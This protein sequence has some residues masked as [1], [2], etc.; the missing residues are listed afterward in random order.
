M[1]LNQSKCGVLTVTRNVNSVQSSYHLI[2]DDHTSTSLIKKIAVQRD[3]G[4]LIT[5]YLKWRKQVNAVYTKA[6]RMLGFIRRTSADMRDPRI[7]TAL[8]KT[9]VRSHFVYSSQVWSPQSVALILDLEKVQRRATRFILS[10]PFQSETSYKDQLLLTGL[11]PLCY[12]HEYL[13]WYIFLQ[14][15]DHEVK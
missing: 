6:S 9:L 13:V 4:V 8:Y 11:L 3:L 10:L 7:R 12:W 1:T 2:N 5:G 15:S 14:S